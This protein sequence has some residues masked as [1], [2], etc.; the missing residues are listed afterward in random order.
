[1][2]VKMQFSRSSLFMMS[3]SGEI[4]FHWKR[5]PSYFFLRF[6]SNFTFH[7]LF[8]YPPIIFLSFEAIEA[9]TSNRPDLLRIPIKA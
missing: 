4:F 3:K 2:P 1:M 9:F 8:A 5:N 7:A 6:C